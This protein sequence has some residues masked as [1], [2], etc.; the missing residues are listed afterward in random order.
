M[1]EHMVLF[2]ASGDLT[3]RLLML[4]VGQLTEAGLL[5]QPFII[6][7]RLSQRRPR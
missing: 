5:P 7:G 6:V 2:R 4:A 3:N 1:I